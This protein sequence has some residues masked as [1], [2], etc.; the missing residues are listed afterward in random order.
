MDTP[1]RAVISSKWITQWCSIIQR[2]NELRDL[3]AE[4]LRMVCNS[5]EVGRSFRRSLG[6]R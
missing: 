3:E 1:T 5:V 2:H 6:R 4:M